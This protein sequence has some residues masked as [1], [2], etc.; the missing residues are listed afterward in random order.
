MP[1]S[2]SPPPEGY[3]DVKWHVPPKRPSLARRK[4]VKDGS[5]K[6]GF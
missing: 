3:P 2:E 1:Y 5:V 6:V 4:R